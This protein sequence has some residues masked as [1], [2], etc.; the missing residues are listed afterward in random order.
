MIGCSGKDWFVSGNSGHVRTEA[1]LGIVGDGLEPD[2]V[3][4][5]LGLLPSRAWR[6]G[7]PVALRSGQTVARPTGYWEYEAPLQGPELTLEERIAALLAAIEPSA[8]AFKAV[9]SGCCPTMNCCWQGSTGLGGPFLSPQLMKRLGDLG[10]QVHIEFF[11]PDGWGPLEPDP[12]DEE[13]AG[14]FQGQ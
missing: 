3:S 8:E 6:K 4:A 14:A 9:T 5:L 10:I 13:E 11:T 2:K 1:C 7:E 12:I